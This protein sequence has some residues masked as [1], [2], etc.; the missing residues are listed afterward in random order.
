MFLR[1]K[2]SSLNEDFA[3]NTAII[4]QTSATGAS[5]KKLYVHRN[6][7]ILDLE[8][9]YKE[10]KLTLNEYHG[11]SMKLTGIKNY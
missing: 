3:F 6:T 1:D 4:T 9:G 11:R 8:K 10:Q 5:L 7:R 2:T